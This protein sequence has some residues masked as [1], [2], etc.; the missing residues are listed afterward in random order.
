MADRTHETIVTFA[1]PFTLPAI[2]SELAAGSYRIVTDEAEILGLS[3]MAYA[4]VA[5]TLHAPAIGA[6]SRRQEVYT[7]PPAELAAAIAADK[8]S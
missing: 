2:G 6:K 5:T 8:L 4:H 3:F 7:I 1:H